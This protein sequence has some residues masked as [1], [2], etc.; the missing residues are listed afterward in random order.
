M[1]HFTYILELFA[2]NT[3]AHPYIEH[4]PQFAMDNTAMEML[5]IVSDRHTLSDLWLYTIIKKAIVP[6]EMANTV[7]LVLST[8]I[9]INIVG[10]I[11]SNVKYFS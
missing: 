1:V 7:V 2:S 10:S 4:H 6:N 11:S 8:N 9:I 5:F 3:A